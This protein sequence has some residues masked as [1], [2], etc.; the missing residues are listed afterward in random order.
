MF[1]QQIL[2]LQEAL[3]ESTTEMKPQLYTFSR[4]LLK[5]VSSEYGLS[6]M[7]AKK[8]ENNSIKFKN[9]IS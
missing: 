4:E 5:E 8:D 2:L 6:A 3:M 9:C 7:I 1:S